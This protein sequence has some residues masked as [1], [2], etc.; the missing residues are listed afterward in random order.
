MSVKSDSTYPMQVRHILNV[1]RLN[2]WQFDFV[3]SQRF[4]NTNDVGRIAVLYDE[5]YHWDEELNHAIAELNVLGRRIGHLASRGRAIS[6]VDSKRFRELEKE[7]KVAERKIRFFKALLRI[8][9][10][11]NGEP[12]VLGDGTY[13]GVNVD[14]VVVA[15]PGVPGIPSVIEIDHDIDADTID[16]STS[17]SDK[18]P[19][20]R[21]DGE[22]D[23]DDDDEAGRLTEALVDGFEDVS[24]VSL[25]AR[26]PFQEPEPQPP[27]GFVHPELFRQGLDAPLSPL[28][29]PEEDEYSRELSDIE[30]LRS[31]S[32]GLEGL[33]EEME[34]ANYQDMVHFYDEVIV[35]AN[36][37]GVV[38]KPC[39]GTNWVAF[40]RKS[41]VI[42]PGLESCVWM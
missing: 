2:Q 41:V 37:L 14:A 35:P 25:V 28:V 5:L 33:D 38:S 16:V 31:P 29:H 13:E 12:F 24:G 20:A 6:D 21:E 26:A 7:K 36:E 1:R 22:D 3:V 34:E 8:L 18:K 11:G 19:A 42:R 17:S 27:L 9:T 40:L 32:P 15:H 23:D 39:V 30:A 10:G 4:N